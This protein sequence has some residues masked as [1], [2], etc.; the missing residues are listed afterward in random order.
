MPKFQFKFF[1]T[2]TCDSLSIMFRIKW[3]Q[4]NVKT[5]SLWASNETVQPIG[6]SHGQCRS[7]RRTRSQTWLLQMHTDIWTDMHFWWN[8][9]GQTEVLALF[10]SWFQ[11]CK[12]GWQRPTCGIPALS[13]NKNTTNEAQ[14]VNTVVGLGI[15]Q[16]ELSII[17]RAHKSNPLCLMCSIQSGVQWWTGG[18]IPAFGFPPPPIRAWPSGLLERNETTQCSRPKGDPGQ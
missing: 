14:L 5:E 10:T 6:L 17:Q 1:V 3:D 18:S 2:F 7:L 13:D 9:H 15:L 12:W 8:T 11:S 16:E 4:G